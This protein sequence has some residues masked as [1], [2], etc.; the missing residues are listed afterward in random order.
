M[1]LA[2]TAVG[3]VAAAHGA[4]DP[5]PPSPRITIAI[6]PDDVGI[7]SLGAVDG[8]AIGLLQTGIGVVPPEQ[9]FI[10]VGQGNR[11]SVSVY[12]DEEPPA[13]DPAPGESIPAA[14]WDLVATRAREA[15]SQLIPGLLASTLEHAEITVAATAASG[16]GALIAADRTG[17]IELAECESGAC[18]G[19][20][21]VG[22]ERA[23]LDRL[24]EGLAGDDLLIALQSPPPPAERLVALGIAG[25]GYENGA[26]L[27]SPS[28]RAG[29]LVITTDIAPTVLGRLGVQVPD[30]MNGDVIETEATA[31]ATALNADADRLYE[32]TIR[33]HSVIGVAVL[34]WL[35][36]ALAAC[37]AAPTRRR[38]VAAVIGLTIL[39][40]PFVQ[41]F[42]GELAPSVT[43]E[44]LMIALAA[45]LL[46]AVTRYLLRGWLAIAAPCAATVVAI[47]AIL[48][49][50]LDALRY[51]II[52]PNL[53]SGGR[54]YGIDNEIEAI[55]A[56]M[57]P[58]G[59]GAWLATRP[60]TRNGG[61]A[62]AGWFVAIGL[63]ATFV[64]A[65]GRLGADV[66]AAIVL[67]VGAA[68]AVAVA[69]NSRRAALVALVSP[70]A[71]L[72]ALFAVD[73]LA[74]GDAHFTRTII[75]ADS[76]GEVLEVIERKL[77][78]M[79]A[80]FG[81]SGNLL[82][83]PVTGA[84]LIFAAARWRT[85]LTWIGER[86][87]VA[88]YAGAAVAAVIGTLTNDSGAVALIYGSFVVAAGVLVA[89]SIEPAETPGV[90]GKRET[91]RSQPTP[92]T[93][94]NPR[95]PGSTIQSG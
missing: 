26:E 6:L 81:R 9:V 39:Y 44:M 94:A 58:L 59:V 95:Y 30:E 61:V 55:I 63:I 1:I 73:A 18:E 14:T 11:T 16:S 12:D 17:S 86:A 46:A 71:G 56:T 69:L 24:V 25:A 78:L 36:A 66:G 67:P 34:A 72:V 62:A 53:I 38:T 28:T 21:V 65:A 42:T 2:A 83:L 43:A 91:G 74:G 22:V 82:L 37:L 79:V 3:P 5:P 48:V 76:F 23:E 13:L 7:E 27:T 60:S 80:S 45:P 10:D 50:G 84:L 40:L 68:T 88:G 41:L 35:A 87:A 77:D 51:S 15:S 32:K 92:P 70:I 4:A 93:P 57:V 90:R 89:W 19:V 75:D 85:V 47:A 20:T 49:F 64:F 33:L 31:D 54:F 8:F 29:G 52:G